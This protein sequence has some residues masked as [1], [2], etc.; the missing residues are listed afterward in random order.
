MANL[1]EFAVCPPDRCGVAPDTTVHAETIISAAD[2]FIGILL[3]TW[4]SRGYQLAP[5]IRPGLGIEAAQG[6]ITC[7]RG[8]HHEQQV[9][10]TC[11]RL[12]REQG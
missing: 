3:A 10:D 1:F 2:G 8:T 11:L 12:F 5:S 4:R 7:S 9:I 6:K